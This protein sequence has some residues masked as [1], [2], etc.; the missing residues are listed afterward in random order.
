[1]KSRKELELLK[2]IKYEKNFLTFTDQ[3]NFF[4][5]LRVH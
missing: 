5:V 3:K 4:E 1:M 2:L